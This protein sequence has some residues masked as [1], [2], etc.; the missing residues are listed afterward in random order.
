MPR[1]NNTM[2][3]TR[4][5]G[6]RDCPNCKRIVETR[7]FADGYGQVP[8]AGGYAKVRKVICGTDAEG[9][10]GCGHIWVTYEIAAEAAGAVLKWEE[11]TRDGEKRKKECKQK[12]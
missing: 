1:R 11:A 10:G 4:S 8:Y 9:T 2:L 7:V 12:P 5:G 3:E 6:H